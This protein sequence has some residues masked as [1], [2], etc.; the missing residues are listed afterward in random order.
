MNKQEFE[1]A[2]KEFIQLYCDD[3]FKTSSYNVYERKNEPLQAEIYLESYSQ[4]YT[5]PVEES[6]GEI[7]IPIPDCSDLNLDLTNLFCYIWNEA[8]NRL[9]AKNYTLRQIEEK[10]ERIKREF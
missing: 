7:V 9:I 8:E 5:V 6:N 3:Y 4:S 10:I 2:I 1:D